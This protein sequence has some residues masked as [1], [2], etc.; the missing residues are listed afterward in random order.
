M[1]KSHKGSN[2]S[3]IVLLVMLGILACV[4]STIACLASTEWIYHPSFC[5]TTIV[6]TTKTFPPGFALPNTSGRVERS[7]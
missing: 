2:R 6:W 1:V 5:I 3:F 4:T 7:W